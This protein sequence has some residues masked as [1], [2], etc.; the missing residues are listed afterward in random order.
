[1]LEITSL[2]S[3]TNSKLQKPNGRAKALPVPGLGF[4][5]WN[6]FE[7]CDLSFGISVQLLFPTPAA[8]SS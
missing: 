3:Q 1:M 2:K 6:L 4:G 8:K 7:I 5:A